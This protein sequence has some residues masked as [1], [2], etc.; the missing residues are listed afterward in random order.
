MDPAAHYCILFTAY[1]FKLIVGS[2]TFVAS[3]AGEPRA[4][5]KSFL[6]LWRINLIRCV[7]PQLVPSST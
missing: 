6:E 5:R 1:D 4:A 7:R 2:S 3:I